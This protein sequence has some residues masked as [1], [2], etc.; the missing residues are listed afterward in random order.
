MRQRKRSSLSIFCLA[1][2]LESGVESHSRLKKERGGEREGSRDRI[3]GNCRDQTL[4]ERYFVHIQ[5]QSV[6]N[7]AVAPPL[8][9]K[10]TVSLFPHF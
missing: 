2:N 6:Q 3:S 9:S 10:S 5:E 1:R 8:N 7:S 4:G